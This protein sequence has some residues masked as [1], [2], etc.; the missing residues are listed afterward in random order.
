MEGMAVAMLA[1]MAVA[2]WIGSRIAQMLELDSIWAAIIYSIIVMAVVGGVVG[3]I[4]CQT[5]MGRGEL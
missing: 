2:Y 3:A 5:K 4:E 1:V